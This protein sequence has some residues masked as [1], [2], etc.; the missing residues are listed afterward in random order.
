MFEFYILLNWLYVYKFCVIFDCFDYLSIEYRLLSIILYVFVN[1]IL[2]LWFTSCIV[3]KLCRI[4]FL[5]TGSILFRSNNVFLN[6]FRSTTDTVKWIELS[7]IFMVR[8]LKYWKCFCNIKIQQDCWF[9]VFKI[10]VC[11]FKFFLCL[12]LPGISI[13]K[14]SYWLILT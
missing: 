14:Q 6:W 2:A 11:I 4:F 7:R 9:C 8:V 12:C 5:H 10:H 1:G 13:V 3:L